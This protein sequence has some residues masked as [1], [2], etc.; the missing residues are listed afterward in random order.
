[1]NKMFDELM[2]NMFKTHGFDLV[3]MTFECK[4]IEC[5]SNVYI[6]KNKLGDYFV[7]WHAPVEALGLINHDIQIEIASAIEHGSLKFEQLSGE[8]LQIESSF[9]KKATLIMYSEYKEEN[10]KSIKNQ[11]IIIEEDPYFFKKQVMLIPENDV[12]VV[13]KGFNTNKDNYVDFI[14]S[15]ISDTERFKAFATRHIHA[16]SDEVVEYAFV[17][18]LYEK[19]P[20]L[21]LKVTESN[22][23]YLQ[24]KIDSSLSKEQVMECEKLL[25][26]DEQNLNGWFAEILK[27]EADD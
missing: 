6:A 8:E 24:N 22:Q 16:L 21:D 7:Y 3:K 20:F 18:K 12:A 25:Q 13:L 1:M 17:A 27:E 15:V 2:E 14:Q 10:E 4:S 19:L 23:E 5:S 9:D 26:L 11:A